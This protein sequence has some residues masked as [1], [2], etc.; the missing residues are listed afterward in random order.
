M[1]LK[2][3]KVGRINIPAKMKKEIGLVTING[4]AKAEVLGGRVI[5]SAVD[6]EQCACCGHMVAK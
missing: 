3:D 6:V 5:I 4:W 2:I 1:L